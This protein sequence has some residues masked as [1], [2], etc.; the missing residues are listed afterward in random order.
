MFVP[1]LYS[2]S[3]PRACVRGFT[4]VY[5]ATSRRPAQILCNHSRWRSHGRSIKINDL[6]EIGLTII[7]VDNNPALA[8]IVYRIQT[9]CRLIFDSSPTFKIFATEDNKIMKGAM[10]I[11]I[12]NLVPVSLPSIAQQIPDVIQLQQGCPKCGSVG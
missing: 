1:L 5:A 7:S 6:E 10:P 4:F 12:P 8:D 11:G 2:S 9:V 3:I